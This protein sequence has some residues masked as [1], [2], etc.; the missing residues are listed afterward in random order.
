MSSSL[1]SPPPA[2]L[3]KN[4]PPRQVDGC[5]K[6]TLLGVAKGLEKASEKPDLPLHVKSNLSIA[7]ISIK[8]KARTLVQPLVKSIVYKR[9]VSQIELHFESMVVACLEPE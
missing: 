3:H 4:V 7:S 9:I 2:D 1:F 5:Q 6:A 8:V